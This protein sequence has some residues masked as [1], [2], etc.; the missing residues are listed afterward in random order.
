MKKQERIPFSENSLDLFRLFAALQVALTHYLNL[1][2]IQYRDAGMEDTLLYGL[3]RI[4]TLFPGLV[5]LFSISGFLMG[6]SLEKKEGRIAF[7]KKRFL[8]I[9]PALWANIL[10]TAALVLI[11]WKPGKH[12][13]RS[14]FVWLGIQAMGIAYTPDFL[15][16][17]GSINGALWTVMVEI[18]LYLLIFL[19][20]N[21]LRKMGDIWWHLLFAFSIL[22]NFACWWLE[23]SGM[24]PDSFVSLMGRT[25]FP[26]L[27]WFAAGLYLYH[28]RQRVLPV[29]TGFWPFLCL[30][31]VLYKALWQHFSWQIPGYYADFVTSLL[32][33]CVVLGGA[34]GFGKHRVKMDLSYGIFLYHWPI[35]NVIF[36]YDLPHRMD[37]LLLFTGYMIVFLGL[38]AASWYLLERHALKI[39]KRIGTGKEQKNA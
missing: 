27:V 36:F 1:F 13:V 20:W 22:M 7:A 8:R 4:L 9:Y 35:I 15:Q 5:I 34:Y 2:M 30:G 24:L 32:L 23:G 33:P 6:A 14:L 18:Q 38:S 10:L 29:L 25:L 19:G 17:F 31:Y 26:Y 39:G 37:H 21:V 11:L 12:G 3:K 16:E 28:F